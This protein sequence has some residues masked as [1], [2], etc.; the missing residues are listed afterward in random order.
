M[1]LKKRRIKIALVVFLASQFFNLSLFFGP[2]QL[3]ADLSTA[4]DT[5]DDNRLSF[6]GALAAGNSEGTST[7]TIDT[8]PSSTYGWA[9][10]DKNFNLFPGDTMMVGTRTGTYSVDDIIDDATDDKIQLDTAL[11][12]G[13]ADTG[14]PV[15]ATRSAV[16]TISLTTVSAITDGAFRVRVKSG[17]ANGIPDATGFD[18]STATWVVGDQACSAGGGTY[19]WGMETATASGQTGCTAGYHC[20]ECRY[21]GAGGIGNVITFTIGSTAKLIN[22]QKS[23]ESESKAVGAADTYAVIIE[24]MN[25]DNTVADDTTVKVAVVEAVRVTATVEPTIEFS[26]AGETLGNTRC[27]VSTDV[28]TTAST[29][30]LGTLSISAFI[31]ASQKLTVSTNGDSYV[32]TVQEDDQLS[33]DGGGTITLADSGGDPGTMTHTTKADWDDPADTDGK[34]FGYSLQ[35]V[36]AAIPAFQWSE[37][38]GACVGTTFCA[39]QFP[40]VPSPDTVQTIFSSSAVADNEDVYFC[41]QIVI[42]ATQQAGDYENR[43]TFIATATF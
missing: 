19:N 34:G 37:T 2:K 15:I 29:V 21:N 7:I 28:T 35:N 36:D 12:S 41:Y 17:D 31:N 9:K 18:F 4:S 5:L 39:K 30:P 23:A 27:G 26:I 16:H 8:S 40:E 13:D 14:D 33:I 43:V 1:F 20:F 25:S 38:D 42:G 22:P 11:L 32:V 24:H 6:V 3:G 10:T